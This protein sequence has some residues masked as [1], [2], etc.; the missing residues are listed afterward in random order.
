MERDWALGVLNDA[1]YELA[2][3]AGELVIAVQDHAYDKERAKVVEKLKALRDARAEALEALRRLQ[4]REQ[5]ERE[6]G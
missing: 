4:D 3:A 2:L 6:C 1:A 5:F